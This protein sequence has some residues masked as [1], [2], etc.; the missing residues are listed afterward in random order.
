ME[1]IISELQ[2]L[3]QAHHEGVPGLDEE[4]KA[5]RA[6]L[7]AAITEGAEPCPDCGNLPHGMIQNAVLNKQVIALY[8][9][10]CLTCRD[11]RAQGLTREVAVTHWNNGEYLPPKE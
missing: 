10:G 4:I 2:K 6:E 5:L 1:K 7:V 11:H 8:E 9:V 3:T